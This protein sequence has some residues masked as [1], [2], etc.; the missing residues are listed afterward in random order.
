ML[1]AMG[2]CEECHGDRP[3]VERVAVQCVSC[4]SYH[5]Q[6]TVVVEAPKS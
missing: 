2:K 4:H 1:P 5:P 3:A 6:R